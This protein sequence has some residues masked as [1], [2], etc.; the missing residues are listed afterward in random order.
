[1]PRGEATIDRQGLTRHE[2]RFIRSEEEHGICDFD[3]LAEPIQLVGFAN[4]IPNLSQTLELQ[5]LIEEWRF[6]KAG[7]HRIDPTSNNEKNNL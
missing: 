6:D 3:G 5:S 7:A 4:A 2:R 1:M